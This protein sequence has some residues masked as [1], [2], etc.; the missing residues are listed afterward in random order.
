VL[1]ADYFSVP[2]ESI[3]DIESVLTVA[4]GKVVHGAG[5][6]SR[7]SPPLPPVAQDWLPVREYGEYYKRTV[8]EA[9]NLAR[10]MSQ[11]GLIADGRDWEG[12][13]CGML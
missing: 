4:G 3:K 10:A 9:Q 2:V 12:C 7:L 8:A 6:F 11:P 13:G 1:S 5:Q